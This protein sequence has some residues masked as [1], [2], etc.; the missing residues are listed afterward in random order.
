MDNIYELA[1]SF[2]TA[3]EKL[4]K[5]NE[6]DAISIAEFEKEE[7]WKLKRMKKITSSTCPKLM[8]ST[9]K[10]PNNWDKTAKAVLYGV[11]YERRTGVMRKNKTLRQFD[12]GHTHEPNAVV[13]YR[14]FIDE[15]LLHASV[16]FDEILLM[17][18]F[19]G[20]GDSPDGIIMEEGRIIRV[21]EI[22]CRES[23]A[24]LESEFAINAISDDH[25][26]FWQFIAHFVGNPEARFVDVVTYDGNLEPDNIQA[27]H[28]VVM[29]R[30]DYQSYIDRL[31]K[32]IKD[33][34]LILSMHENPANDYTIEDAK[35]IINNKN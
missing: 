12:W 27:G 2:L 28:V 21:I 24:V 33:A 4:K 9:K 10:D 19:E 3:A 11:A 35:T 7:R 16:D 31:E 30:E 29:K 32:R 14:K 17:E 6:V 20:F 23:E 1:E 34:L 18:P 25:G 15:D 5:P 8:T 26:D 13:W 22:K